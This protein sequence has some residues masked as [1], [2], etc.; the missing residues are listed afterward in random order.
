MPE[1][2]PEPHSADEGR[3]DRLAIPLDPETALA[4]L[5]QVDPESEP[6]PGQ[7]SDSGLRRNPESR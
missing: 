5:L 4:A 2:P 1:K 6:T 7:D 3:D